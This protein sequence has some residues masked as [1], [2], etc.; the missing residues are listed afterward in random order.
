LSWTKLVVLSIC[1]RLLIWPDLRTLESGFSS[2][3]T[4]SEEHWIRFCIYLRFKWV[5]SSHIPTLL[6]PTW[7]L[8][9]SLSTTRIWFP[10]YKVFFQKFLYVSKLFGVSFTPRLIL[11]NI[12][13]GKRHFDSSLSETP[14]L[15]VR[16]PTECLCY[17]IGGEFVWE[18]HYDSSLW[19]FSLFGHKLSGTNR[20]PFF[21]CWYCCL[22]RVT[23]TMELRNRLVWTIFSLWYYDSA[24]SC[25]KTDQ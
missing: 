9:L 10:A 2:T 5:F 18:G 21:L 23:S 12:Y 24:F 25:S 20:V 16:R 8:M 4:S 22:G 6:S 19:K 13:F 15:L 7:S 11:A 3:L 1:R 17:C 14:C